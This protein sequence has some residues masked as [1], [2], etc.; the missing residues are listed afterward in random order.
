MEKEINK[1]CV[2]YPKLEVMPDTEIKRLA[3][4]MFDEGFD[5]TMYCGLNKKDN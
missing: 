2:Y 1:L 4:K 3:L 5:F